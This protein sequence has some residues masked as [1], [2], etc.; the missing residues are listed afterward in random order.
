MGGLPFH[1]IPSKIVVEINVRCTGCEEKKFVSVNDLCALTQSNVSRLIAN[2][3]RIN[4]DDLCVA[5]IEKVCRIL[6][7]IIL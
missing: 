1:S 2:T 5:V 3:E 4:H 7:K 6:R